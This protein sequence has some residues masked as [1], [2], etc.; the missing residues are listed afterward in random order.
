MDEHYLKQELYGLFRKD[1]SLFEFLQAGSLDGVWYWNLE[2]PTDEWMS[3][4]FWEILGYDP[5]EKKHLASEWQDLIFEDDLKVATE[6]FKQHCAD[7]RHPY[8]QLVRYRHKNGSTVWIR[9]RG[10][11]IRDETGKPIRMLGVHTNETPIKEA[12]SELRACQLH[13]TQE[14]TRLFMGSMSNL[15]DAVGMSTP[16][17][18]HYYQNKAF[19]ELFGPVG[20]NPGESLY[21]DPAVGREVFRTIMAG[22]QWTGEV[23]MYAKDRS[24]LDILLRAY[25]NKD[26]SGRI[27]ALVGIHTDISM[28]KQTEALLRIND[29]AVASAIAGIAISDMD[30]RINF[31]NAAWLRMHGYDSDADVKGTTPLQHVRNPADAEAVI[32]AIKQKESWTGELM[33]RRRDGSCFTAELATNLM[34]DSTGRTM[35]LLASFQDVTKRRKAEDELRASEHEKALILDGIADIIAYHDK[36]LHLVWANQAYLNGIGSIT[37]NPARME[38][39]RGRHCCEAWKLPKPC[40]GCPVSIAL[41]TGK[42]NETELTPENQPHWP[43]TQG[44]WLIKASPV[45]DA[46]GNVIGAIEISRNITERKKLEADRRELDARMNQTQRLESLGVL[47]GGIAHDFNNILMAILGH[48]DLALDEMSPLASGRESLEQIKTAAMRAAELCTQMLAYSG[49]GRLEKQDFCLS[50]LVDEM[51]HMLRTCISKKCVMNLNLEKQLFLMHGDVSQIR[52]VL[53]NLVMNASEAIG[54]RSGSI[55]VSTGAADCSKEYLEQHYIVHPLNAGLYVY[56]EVSD[57][58]C[59]MSRE[60][61]QRMFEPFFTTKFTG[62]GLGLSAILG[63]VK[64]HGGALRVYSELGKGTTIKVLFPATNDTEFGGTELPAETQWRGRGTVLLVDDEET[65]RAVTGKLLERLGLDVLTATDGQEGVA[66]YRDRKADIAVVLLDLTMP[67]MNGEEAFRQLRQINPDVRV[68]LAS[69]YSESDIANRFAG[70]GLVGCIQK[71]YTL[72]RLRS[73]L[74]ALLPAADAPRK[75]DQNP[76]PNQA[77]EDAVRKPADP[78]R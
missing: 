7:A 63:I 26:S 2:K 11:A 30:G 71:P 18:K 8:D 53:M 12:E 5:A 74:S 34:T 40:I 35:G 9:C 17:G 68:I 45:H 14:E 70:K 60:T 36:N 42:T 78:Q 75:V 76:S 67:H 4:R 21:V 77:P 59:G 69:G 29:A 16:E 24:I 27:T 20:E 66:L 22:G 65:V 52:Q 6:H 73:M 64:A 13:A 57:T 28:L 32:K 54:E 1:N 15:S 38:D 55:T 62:R 10:F 33:C 56:L 39:V 49:K 31:V 3:P 37:G 51:L 48:A 19:D 50:S 23:Q 72:A 44:S 58:G 61:I 46:Q 47:A 25:A 43:V 41:E